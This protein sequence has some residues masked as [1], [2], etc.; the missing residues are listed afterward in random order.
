MSEIYTWEDDPQSSTNISPIKLSPPDLG[1]NFLPIEIKLAQP[2]LPNLYNS[3][4]KEFRYWN[5]A[6][7]L[8]RGANFWH[9]T[10]SLDKWQSNVGLILPIFLDAGVDLNAYYNR[11]G[12][13]FFHDTVSGKT[14][15]SGE[16]PD[17]LCHELGHA[18]LDALKP[19]LWGVAS[20]EA[21]AFHE[22]FG[23]VSALLSALQLPSVRQALLNETGGN[24]YRSTRLSRLAEQLG[25]A[26]RVRNGSDAVDPDC[27]RNAVNSLFYQKP[28]GLPPRAPASQLSNEPHSFSRLFTGAFLEALAS[29]L[30]V[31]APSPS[32]E[33]LL[34][35]SQIIAKLLVDSV[36]KAPIT[37]NYFSQVAAYMIQTDLSN[38]GKYSDVLKMAFIKHGI[39]SIQ[40]ASQLTG[41]QRAAATPTIVPS[42]NVSLPRVALNGSK[43][44]LNVDA[45]LVDSPAEP[46][47][48]QVGSASVSSN[49]IIPTQAA[50]SFVEQLLQQGNIDIQRNNVASF[51]AVGRDSLRKSHSLVEENGQLV[52]KRNYFDCR[53]QC[54]CGKSTHL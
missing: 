18:V 44:G 30:L 22:S 34:E 54:K 32:D 1:V 13:S 42:I 24:L 15:Y 20:A 2:P 36:S 37:P 10:S 41:L 23:D 28:E 52:L 25:W 12:L 4:T 9:K 35:I 46:E 38:D 19:Q 47:L 45:I 43:F 26:I 53:I 7:A 50:Q 29:M 16:S 48:F 51:A 11:E 21:A 39:L 40:A 33:N 27:L 49:T 8:R 17:I 14:V 3:D 5:A 6:A 31:L